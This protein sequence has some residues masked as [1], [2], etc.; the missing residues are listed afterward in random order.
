M[1]I[2]RKTKETDISLDLNIYGKGEAE[3]DLKLRDKFLK[4]MLETLAR[5]G[6][7]DLKLKARGDNKHHVVEDL[8]IVLGRA[9]RQSLGKRRMKRLS[10]AVVAMDD[11]LVLVALDLIDRPYVSLELPNELY[12][13][14]LRSFV[15]EAKFTAQNLILR[16][17]DEHHII[18]ATF[19]AFGCA[20]REAIKEEVRIRSTKEEAEWK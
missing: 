16:G 19:K 5:F 2:K 20:L 4:H 1:K 10:S 17:K 8:A 14:F 7:F 13:H 9:F 6:A 11:A 18:E 12:Q 15:L 3:I